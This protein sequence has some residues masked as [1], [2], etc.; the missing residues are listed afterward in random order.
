MGSTGI[1]CHIFD[2]MLTFHDII[3]SIQLS[4]NCNLTVCISESRPDIKNLTAT[5][6]AVPLKTPQT[7]LEG[8]P[9][10]DLGDRF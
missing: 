2:I 3:T 4:I 9:P 1:R 5:S 7:K 8:I 6:Y 10:K